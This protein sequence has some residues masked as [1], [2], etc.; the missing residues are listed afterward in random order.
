MTSI[1]RG[2]NAIILLIDVTNSSSL[3]AIPDWL[4]E[5]REFSPAFAVI[6]LVG[7]KVDSDQRVLSVEACQEISKKFL[8]RYSEVSSKT[9]DGVDRLFASI[10]EELEDRTVDERDAKEERMSLNEMER[11]KSK[12]E[13]H[14]PLIDG[15]DEE[16]ACCRCCSIM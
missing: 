9:G 5:I 16:S 2:A 4:H 14:D 1:Y 8:L 10:V 6:Y 3:E 11:K 7:T 12:R 15:E 13:C